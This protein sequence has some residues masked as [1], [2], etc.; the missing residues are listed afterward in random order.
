[1]ILRDWVI[2]M[3]QVR[4]TG[5]DTLFPGQYVKRIFLKREVFS[6]LENDF[7]SHGRG[8]YQR[9][10]SF[11]EGYGMENYWHAHFS[12]LNASEV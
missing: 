12:R 1:M 3:A 5:Y 8:I 9:L 2:R 10:F 7:F 11:F 6:L 4:C